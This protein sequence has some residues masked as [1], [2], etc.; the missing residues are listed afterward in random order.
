MRGRVRGFAPW[1]P[2]EDARALLAHVR[3]VLREYQDYLPLSCRQIYYRLIGRGVIEKDPKVAKNLNEMLNRARRGGFI[4]FEDIRDDGLTEYGY[5]YLSGPDAAIAAMR[6]VIESYKLDPMDDQRRRLLLLCEAAGVVP[7][8]A[9]VCNP[10]GVSV[11]SSGGFDSTTVKHDL[12]D[13]LAGVDTI[14]LH[15]GDYDPSGIHLF[16]SLEEDVTAFLGDRGIAEFRRLAVTQRQIKRLGLA[17]QPKNPNDNRGFDGVD[18]DGVSTCQLEAIAPDELA[19]IVHAAI[20]AEIDHATLTKTISRE[21][22]ESL[23]LR[24]RFKELWDEES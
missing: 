8:L 7:Q 6:A 10:F 11:L 14:I 23:L 21:H 1:N 12:A 16:K 2:G 4:A 24:T 3:A 19:R 13:R 20:Y 15:V 9:S 17:T 5:G 22:L 18:G